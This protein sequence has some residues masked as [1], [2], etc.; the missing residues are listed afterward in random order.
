MADKN[1]GVVIINNKDYIDKTEEFFNNNDFTHIKRNPTSSFNERVKIA[2]AKHEEFFRS[3][4]IN[5]YYLTPMSPRIPLMYSLIKLHKPDKPVRPIISPI[6]SSTYRLSKHLLQY[7]REHIDFKPEYTICNRDELIT[8]LTAL[9]LP[10]CFTMLSFDITNMYTNIPV[11]EA[12]QMA[13]DLVLEKTQNVNTSDTIFNLLK[14]CT[15]QNFC[16]FNDKIYRYQ[17]GLPMGNSLSGLLSGIFLSALE[18]QFLNQNN[19]NII[20]WR[21]YVD[22]VLVLWDGDNLSHIEN[23]H[24]YINTAHPNIKYTIEIEQNNNLKFLDLSI[25]KL[26]DSLEFDIY[27][28]PT[29]TDTII[30]MDS[31]HHHAHVHAA[32]NCYL[33]RCF[34]VPLSENNRMK[35]IECIH[36]IA[37]NNGFTDVQFKKL[38]NR[39]LH[40]R[41][42]LN[43]TTLTPINTKN[44][45][46]YR[47]IPY[48]GKHAYKLTNIFKKY[49]IHLTFKTSN[50]LK[51]S[52]FNA[53]DKIPIS[54]K[55]G[56]YKL[57]CNTCKA[58]YVGE[59]GRS[60][61]K[62]IKEHID[63]KWTLTNNPKKSNFATH[64]RETGHEFVESD[65]I[66]YLHTENKGHRLDLLEHFE[67][68]RFIKQNPNL[69]CLNDQLYTSKPPL[70]TYLK[71]PFPN[72]S[73]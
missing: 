28:K 40:R 41:D 44:T 9:Q 68:T 52:I 3:H 69:L 4:N 1:A 32:I 16:K 36:A 13:K 70:Y 54:E 34:K 20:F 23:F 37:N 26:Q 61:Q 17:K 57:N 59:T 46:V 5:T 10:S 29:Q 50:S 73:P 58:A 19:K 56:V 51:D 24:K 35:E 64:I 49:N 65:N 25:T 38:L 42:L 45:L 62:R 8:Q 43:T 60:F 39:Q 55:S 6:G 48:P 31:H 27:R 7:F 47:S 14:I 53:K 11:P 22:D 30:P 63:S 33:D 12:L 72:I 71:H 67:I 15:E 18:S 21:R 66:Q 2:I